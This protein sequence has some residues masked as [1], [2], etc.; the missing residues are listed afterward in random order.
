MID[1]SYN[2]LLSDFGFSRIRHDITRSHTN[3]REGGRLRFLAP[4]LS[5]G[6]N[7]KF[8][9]SSS[10]DIFSFSLTVLNAWAGEVPFPEHNDWAATAVIRK[11]QRPNRPVTNINLPPETEHE[12]WLLLVEMW[13]HEASSRPSTEDVCR[14]LETCLGPFS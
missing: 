7:E 5:A 1:A 2:A 8:R 4:E 9:T 3:I 10:S 11:N 13:A 14:R 6:F 12:L